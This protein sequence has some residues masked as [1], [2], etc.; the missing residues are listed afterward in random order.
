MQK[1]IK[2]FLNMHCN[3]LTKSAAYCIICGMKQIAGIK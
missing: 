3:R 1:F 2:L